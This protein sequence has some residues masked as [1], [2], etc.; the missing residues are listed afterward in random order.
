MK[1]R[2][3]PGYFGT[4]CRY[5]KKV[6]KLHFGIINNFLENRANRYLH[7][8]YGGCSIGFSGTNFRW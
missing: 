6:T 3:K 7:G 1:T 5:Q 4:A 8:V 2:K